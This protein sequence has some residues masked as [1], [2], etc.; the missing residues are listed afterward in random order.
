MI[1]RNRPNWLLRGLLGVSLAIHLVIFM[2]LSGIYR[3]DALSYIELT[4]RDMSRPAARDIPRPRCRPKTPEVQEVHRL[5]ATQRHVPR[6]APM[7]LEPAEKNLPDSLME[8]IAMPDIPDTP[9][10]EVADWSPGALL[11]DTGG[12]FLTAQNYLEMVRLKIESHKK[13]PDTARVRNIEG[14]VTIR[15]V[16]TLEGAVREVEVTEH[17]RNRV[18]DLAA[19]RAVKDAAPFSRPPRRFFEGDVPLELTIVFELT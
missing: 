6:L 7:K 17:S 3:S 18:L 9:G 8:G 2:H 11:D 4:M 14:R 13:Y 5:N 16:I 19:V 12:D 10:L 15:F 1:K